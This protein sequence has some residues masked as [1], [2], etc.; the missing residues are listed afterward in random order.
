MAREVGYESLEHEIVRLCEEQKEI[1]VALYMLFDLLEE[2]A[3]CWY[4][5]KYHEQALTALAVSASE[6]FRQKLLV[7]GNELECKRLTANTSGGKQ[8]TEV[9]KPGVAQGRSS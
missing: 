1:L 2:Y 5:E 7:K 3:P 9:L 8:E 6:A 4:T